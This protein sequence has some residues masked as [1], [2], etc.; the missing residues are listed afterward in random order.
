MKIL[1]TISLLIFAFQ[2]S[3]G[4]KDAKLIDEQGKIDCC[5]PSFQILLQE[6]SDSNSKG[7]III[8]GDKT[9]K[10]N[11]Y[12]YEQQIKSWVGFR[13]NPN[14]LILHG[15]SEEKIRTQFWVVPEGAKPPDFQEE[16]W[17]YSLSIKKPLKLYQDFNYLEYGSDGVCDFS[18]YE[19]YTSIFLRA[20]PNLN[21]NLIIYEKSVPKFTTKKLELLKLFNEQ[22]KIPSNRLRFFQKSIKESWSNGEIWL[23]PQKKKS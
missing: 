10:L 19:L 13:D 23:I 9:N 4:Q 3:F 21:A 16:T 12:L 22:Y 5:Y 14:I 2:I 6:I 11:S 7:Y 8:F 17:D 1:L 15:K 20:N 18:F